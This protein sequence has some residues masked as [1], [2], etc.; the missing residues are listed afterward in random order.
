MSNQSGRFTSVRFITIAFALLCLTSG[1]SFLAYSRAD[2]VSANSNTKQSVSPARSHLTSRSLSSFG[3]NLP[4]PAPN[5]TIASNTFLGGSGDDAGTGV[6]VDG[7]GNVYGV[8][9]RLGTWVSPIRA[10]SGG[11]HDVFVAKLDS[12]GNL[13]WNTFLGGS[14]DDAGT[15]V[16]VDASGNVYV[17]G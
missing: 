12:S 1:L 2:R 3:F 8:G 4:Q 17:T 15:R 7:G 10:F 16:A 13:L 6:A 9:Y 5:P 14:G 11:S